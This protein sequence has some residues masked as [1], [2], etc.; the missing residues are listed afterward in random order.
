[1]PVTVSGNKSIAGNTYILRLRG[2]SRNG[3][4]GRDPYGSDDCMGREGLSRG[5]HAIL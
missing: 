5:C 1:M 4:A 2:V 3:E